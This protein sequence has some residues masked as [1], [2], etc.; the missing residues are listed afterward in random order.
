M[1]HTSA[2][3][4]QSLATS[5]A[6]ATGAGRNLG[7]RALPWIR[8]VR[9]AS[10]THSTT[11]PGHG[12]D[13]QEGFQNPERL[14][15][16]YSDPDHGHGPHCAWQRNKIRIRD[17]RRAAKALL[18]RCSTATTWARGDDRREQGQVCSAKSVCHPSVSL[19]GHGS[20]RMMEKRHMSLRWKLARARWKTLRCLV[21]V[22]RTPHAR[23]RST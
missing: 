6:H 7:A 13:L 5:D 8:T 12:L 2:E 22:A 3:H 11:G 20:Q 14:G 16:W 17:S 4:T 10:V 19:D 23:R 1:K 18:S 15:P 9:R 21:A